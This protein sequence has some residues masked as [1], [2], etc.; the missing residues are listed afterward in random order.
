MILPYILLGYIAS[1][2]WS[3]KQHCVW[4]LSLGVGLKSH[5]KWVN[6]SSKLC[7]TVAYLTGKILL[8][9][10]GFVAGLVSVIIF[11]IIYD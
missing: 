5:Q 6:Y 3:P 9:I 2:S 7:V 11:N 10:K 8:E 1:G 4:V